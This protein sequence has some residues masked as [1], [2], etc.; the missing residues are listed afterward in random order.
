M[1]IL[2]TGTFTLSTDG[3]VTIQ[4][5]LRKF[6]LQTN[7]YSVVYRIPTP[8]LRKHRRVNSLLD[9][10]QSGGVVKRE[11]GRERMRRHKPGP[12]HT[13]NKRQNGNLNPDYPGHY[14]LPVYS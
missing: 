6:P 7:A 11:T 14:L 10:S 3:I 9:V 4:L 1:R 2:A 5:L 13:T 12:N 8:T